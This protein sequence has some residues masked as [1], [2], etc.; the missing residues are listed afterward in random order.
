MAS[1]FTK[2]INGEIPCYKIAETANCFAF[3]DIFPLAMG[4]T[5]VIPKKEIDYIF[6]VDDELLS[7]LQLFSKKVAK[8]IEKAVP[9]KRIGVAVIGL[10]VA[11]AHIHL[12][13]LN[14]VGD[15]DFTKEKLKP[16]AEELKKVQAE[17]CKYL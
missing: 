7:E 16:S 4:H 17:I 6:D 13:P 5:L 12:V 9:C 10:E 15:L 1:I 11:H 8:A 14:N 2:I 3:L